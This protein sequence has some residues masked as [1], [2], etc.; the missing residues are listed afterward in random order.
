MYHTFNFVSSVRPEVN[1]DMLPRGLVVFVWAPVHH[2]NDEAIDSMAYES[3]IEE[4][5]IVPTAVTDDC[6]AG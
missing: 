2:K 1:L 3:F 4:T 5:I 6:G